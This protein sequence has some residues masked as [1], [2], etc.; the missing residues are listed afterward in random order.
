VIECLVFQC[1]TVL[2]EAR[3]EVA[4]SKRAVEIC[5]SELVTMKNENDKLQFRLEEEKDNTKKV[6]EQKSKLLEE[7]S[8][9]KSIAR[10]LQDELTKTR[11]QMESNKMDLKNFYQGQVELVVQSKLK[12]F[13][14]Q[15]DEA[16]KALKAE[17][18]KK[19]L[20]IAK[21]A[22]SHI[23]QIS[24]KYCSGDVVGQP[25]ICFCKQA[26]PRDQIVGGETPGGMSAVPAAGV[27]TAARDRR[28]QPED[29]ASTRPT[30][31][32][33]EATAQI[34]GESATGSRDHPGRDEFVQVEVVQ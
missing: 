10:G 12:E 25:L 32:H 5:Q 33:R 19:E 17:L 23:Q 29:P 6:T 24:E 2:A 7:V 34:H 30:R 31:P 4:Q 16:E 11:E 14:N 18:S 3:K 20:S 15:L 13:Q 8:A 26:L 22:A 27:P 9:H 1:K 21:T 28:L